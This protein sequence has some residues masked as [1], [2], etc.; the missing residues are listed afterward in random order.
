MITTVRPAGG[1]R[2][3]PCRPRRPGR[4]PSTAIVSPIP[5]RRSKPRGVFLPRFAAP[6]GARAAS[7]GTVQGA[8]EVCSPIR[9]RTQPLGSTCGHQPSG[10]QELVSSWRFAPFLR[11]NR[12][13]MARHIVERLTKHRLW[14]PRT[15][16]A[17][18]GGERALLQVLFEELANSSSILG[19]SQEPC[20]A[21]G[22]SSS[23]L[24][25]VTLDG[26]DPDPKVR[27]A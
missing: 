2:R 23:G 5:P 1:A 15:R 22:L 17:P 18:S 16:S 20:P 13:G 26:G 27:A 21:L 8:S 4:E 24:G 6:P 7:P 19:V 10:P 14:P 3:A 9:P 25:S 11:S 12:S